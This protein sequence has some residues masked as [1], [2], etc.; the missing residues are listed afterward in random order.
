MRMNLW[1]PG[2]R[3]AG[4]VRLP[5]YAGKRPYLRNV[6]L[7]VS[8]AVDSLT[9][10][11][12]RAERGRLLPFP[13]DTRHV[14]APGPGHVARPRLVAR[15]RASAGTPL[16]S[17]V[18]PVGYGKTALVAEW[19]HADPRQF[20]WLSLEAADNDPER[21]SARIGGPEA[22]EDPRP[23]V[24]V[25]DEMQLLHAPAAIATVRRVIDCIPRLSQ[26]VLISRRPPDLPLGRLRAQRVVT[27]IGTRDLAMSSAEAAALLEA[28]GVVLSRADHDLLMTR[29]EGWPAALYLAAVA[30]HDLGDASAAVRSF[31]GDDAHVAAYLREEVLADMSDAQCAF[32][33]RA[34]VLETLSR[35]ACDSV[36]ARGDSAGALTEAGEG[37]GLL[38]PLDPARN[39]YRWHPLLREMLAGE[40]AREDPAG[41]R[42]LHRRAGA[43][44]LARGDR[45]GAIDHA[46]AAGDGER[47]A[48]LVCQ[49]A[50][51]YITHGRNDE[52]KRRLRMLRAGMPDASPRLALIA[53]WSHLAGGDIVHAR[54][55]IDRLG[56]GDR[57][58]AFEAG[59]SLLRAV[60]DG[61][62]AADLRARAE[63]ARQ[64]AAGNSP[65]RSV[66]LLFEGVG[67]HLSGQR[68]AAE[69]RLEEGARIAAIDAPSVQ[70]LCLAQ[71][72]LM[73][74]ERDDWEAGAAWG[75]RALAQVQHYGLTDYPTSAIVFA[76]SAL[77]RSRRG[78]IDEARE[79]VRQARRG[80]RALGDFVPWYEAE[81]HL[82]LARAM[83]HMGD[84]ADA[85]ESLERATRRAR[86]V[87][88]IAILD[89]WIEAARVEVETAVTAIVLGPLSLTKAEL[90]V[91]RFLP[92]H[93]SFR[94]IAGRL[95]VSANTVK[96]QAHSVYRKLEAS[97]RSEAVVRATELGL[98]GAVA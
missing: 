51:G 29:T 88:G 64:T 32:L 40:L 36:F 41:A 12:Q 10:V 71:L 58:L 59:L 37:N 53:G 27:E 46:S 22:V 13:R 69:A 2:T 49:A 77:V 62:G 56:A 94:E 23:F 95:Y 43:W 91:L 74:A 47:A 54:R 42:E 35:Q 9:L 85:R 14:P 7:G 65:W 39:T 33:L 52:L 60:V 38:V 83:V 92:T 96:T 8:R 11:E 28:C 24:L 30:A 48:E 68:A 90:R 82:A 21:L 19:S 87:S 63:S 79:D 93:L 61:D 18:A 26:L 67:L 20:T 81:A 66:C 76:A 86:S 31:G 50:A 16:V 73:A 89:E 6:C 25:L 17:V 78:M 75:S 1:R 72:T 84:V 98:L 70:T 97:S 15:L 45:E 4:G 57:D 3:F 5:A 80:L 34:S 55:A 44:C